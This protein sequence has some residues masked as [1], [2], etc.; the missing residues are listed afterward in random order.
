MKRLKSPREM[1]RGIFILVASITVFLSGSAWA[2]SLEPSAPPGPTMKTLDEIPPTWSQILPASTRFVLVMGGVAVLDKETGLVWEQSPTAPPTNPNTFEWV[3]AQI[4][5]I[6]LTVGNRKG[7]RLP[8]LQELESLVDPTQS[9]PALPTGHPFSNVQS[10]PSGYWS[11]STYAMNTINAWGVRF[12]NGIPG[13]GDKS[14]SN[15]VWCVR[16]GQGVD[17][18]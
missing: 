11:A 1:A 3:Y 12:D 10:S 13:A 4:H 6:T 5:C 18:Q 15:L 2:G 14:F 7:W 9:N 8:T 16:G 17:P